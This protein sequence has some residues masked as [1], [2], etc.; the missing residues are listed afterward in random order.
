MTTCKIHTD[1][2]ISKNFSAPGSSPTEGGPTDEEA[3]YPGLRNRVQ[4]PGSLDWS[5]EEKRRMEERKTKALSMLSKLQDDTPR[6]SNNSEGRSNFEDCEFGSESTL[7]SETCPVQCEL[8]KDLTSRSVPRPMFM[9][10][11]NGLVAPLVAPL[12]AMEQK[13]FA[14]RIYFR[15]LIYILKYCNSLFKIDAHYQHRRI[16]CFGHFIYWL[17]VWT[18]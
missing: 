15:F 18:K 9:F 7:E 5:P 10:Q 1:F 17:N 6:Q 11:A 8:L 13:G 12:V 16:L 14:Q 2:L 3:N 4:R